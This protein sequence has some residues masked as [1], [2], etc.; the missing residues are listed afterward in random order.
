MDCAVK[1]GSSEEES[2]E[3]KLERSKDPDGSGARGRIFL[4]AEKQ[5]I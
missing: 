2:F 5:H 3:L 4:R 1:Q